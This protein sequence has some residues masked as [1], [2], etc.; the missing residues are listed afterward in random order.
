MA[1]GHQRRPDPVMEKAPP[2]F[3]E[4]M[5]VDKHC[6][7]IDCGILNNDQSY[8]EMIDYGSIMEPMEAFEIM[9][10][11]EINLIVLEIPKSVT[12]KQ[13]LAS[14]ERAP[15]PGSS[16]FSP[17]DTRCC[18][19]LA[20]PSDDEVE[21]LSKLGKNCC[22]PLFRF[23]RDANRESN[24]YTEHP[25]I[26][27]FAMSLTLAGRDIFCVELFRPDLPIED[28]WKKKRVFSP[29]NPVKKHWIHRVPN[30]PMKCEW[31]KALCNNLDRF[32]A[33]EYRKQKL[34]ADRKI[35]YDEKRNETI[36]KLRA[37]EEERKK[38]AGEAPVM[39]NPC[40]EIELQTPKH[41]PLN[42]E[43]IEESRQKAWAADRILAIKY[44][45]Q[46]G[47]TQAMVQMAKNSGLPIT[48]AV[49]GKKL[50]TIKPFHSDEIPIIKLENIK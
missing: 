9:D 48:T 49:Q 28:K 43:E 40:A 21:R 30:E 20:A 22:V 13:F 32:L 34:W 1:F 50:T 18:Y 5:P 10:A 8:T 37:E 47:K 41:Q 25:I 42:A 27:S 39:T 31:L 17:S 14:Y 11:G 33:D 16:H 23:S 45:R 36:K 12:P 35:I 2:P 19:V 29:S 6:K 7:K 46:T 26:N 15:G 4:P 44:G 24:D 3:E 38:K